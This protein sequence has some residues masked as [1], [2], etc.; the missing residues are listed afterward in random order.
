MSNAEQVDQ[1]IK[2]QFAKQ[3][4][5]RDWRLFKKMSEW[6]LREAANLRTKDVA[7]EDDL[8]LL[9]R[10]SRKRLLIGIGV[11][12]LLK[13]VYLKHGFLINSPPPGST[14]QVPF[15]TQDAAGIQLSAD[16]TIK[17]DTL[18]AKLPDVIRLSSQGSTLSGLRIAKAFRNKEGHVVTSVH[19]FD[20]SNFTDIAQAISDLY[21]DA[22]AE[23]LSLQ[24]SIAPNQKA[25][26]S[27]RNT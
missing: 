4:V 3:F 13:S 21:R 15:S 14:L 16:K 25:V 18:I 20:A 6:N 8:K 11:E 22:F 23:V 17:F 1:A 9:A 24:F 27:V 5:A 26:W 7:I 2:L 10:N 19:Q 12:L